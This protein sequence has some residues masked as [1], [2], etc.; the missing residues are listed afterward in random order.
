ML[1]CAEALSVARAHTRLLTAVP[2]IHSTGS[3]RCSMC[4]VL[5]FVL[6]EIKKFVIQS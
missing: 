3:F 1:F 4:K 2:V 5:Y 6:L